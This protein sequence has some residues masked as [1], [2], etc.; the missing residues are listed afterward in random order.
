MAE[1]NE[2]V[3]NEKDNGKMEDENYKSNLDW[4]SRSPTVREVLSVGGMLLFFK[5][6]SCSISYNSTAVPIEQRNV[7]GD[8]QPETFIER[9]EVR[10][11]SHIDGRSID[12]LVEE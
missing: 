3:E 8:D 1:V 7:I 6:I 9:E 12:Y 4:L 11:Y 2:D 5:F 10:Y